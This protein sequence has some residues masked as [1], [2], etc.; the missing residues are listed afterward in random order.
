MR[1]WCAM[2]AGLV[3]SIL[4]AAPVA[5]QCTSVSE[6]VQLLASD[7]GASD[8][9]GISV[10][11]AGN[12]A[13]AG[14][15]WD[16]TPA[17]ANAGSAYVFTR[18]ALGVWTQ[19]YKMTAS[20]GA[21]NDAFGI[22]VAISGNTIVVGAWTDVT[23]PTG[24]RTGSAYVF[25][26]V[27]SSWYQTH[28]LVP[29][30]G[31][32]FDQ[33]GCAVAVYEKDGAGVIAVGASGDDH[34]SVGNNVGSVYT[35]SGASHAWTPSDK[36]SVGSPGDEFG[37]A[38]AVAGPGP[39]PGAHVLVGAPKA[40][41]AAGADAG[42]V[43]G[44]EWYDWPGPLP[45]MG[46][47]WRGHA[48][49]NPTD[50][51]PGDMLGSSVAI[52]PEV[53]TIPRPFP[54]PPSVQEGW[55]ARVGVPGDDTPAG[56][57]AGSVYNTSFFASTSF[58]PPSWQQGGKTTATDGAP[59]DRFGTSVA[60]NEF[61]SAVGAYQDDTAGGADA[62]SVYVYRAGQ[63]WKLTASNGATNDYFGT[64]VAL[65]GDPQDPNES[66]IVVGAIWDDTPAGTDA[67]SAYVYS[68]VDLPPAM[69]TIL[70]ATE[71]LPGRAEIKWRDN[72]P[73]ETQFDFQRQSK[74]G[75]TW[76]STALS[77]SSPALPG[78]GATEEEYFNPGSGSWRYAVRATNDAGSSAWTP[79]LVVNPAAPTNLSATWVAG[80]NGHNVK[81]TWADRSG[82]EKG[83]KVKRQ[84]RVA[85]VWTETTTTSSSQ[86]GANATMFIDATVPSAGEY[87]FRAMSFN[88]G[89][90]SK[91]TPWVVITVP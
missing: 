54:E 26:R 70:S 55:S 51:A 67:G 47:Y 33:F 60:M 11:A 78:T 24:T 6:V 5:G 3:G 59:G 32:A 46:M 58:F 13:V 12:T 41:T 42:K 84:R 37:S 28:K 31:A 45:P 9:M 25:K 36:L 21:A 90:K 91:W 72:S 56:A 22:S 49:P 52:A 39:G 1:R 75:N 18:N 8:G 34:P 48:I 29:A 40:D 85:G 69:P 88:D 10:A 83:F 63:V 38:V 27:G 65:G 62:G 53:F 44:F 79:Y 87:R 15:F 20:D 68:V 74:V 7:G 66:T 17:G 23:A 73:C 77:G 57:D 80:G 76:G 14:A 4:A 61:A 35:Y 2:A 16:D 89:G 86:I 19:S 81:L 71:T 64:S 43:Y 50:G 30:D 82:F